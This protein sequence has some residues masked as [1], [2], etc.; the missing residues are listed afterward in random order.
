[1]TEKDVYQTTVHIPKYIREEIKNRGMTV[2]GAFLAGWTAIQD[3]VK[4]SIRI[5]ELEAENR[6]MQQNIRTAQRQLAK[7]YA[8]GIDNASTPR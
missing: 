7:L 5:E 1:M 4:Y 8:E 3:R 2:S 6:E